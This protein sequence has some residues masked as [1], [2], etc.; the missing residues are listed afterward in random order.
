M[1]I[2]RDPKFG[3][4]LVFWIED[5]NTLHCMSKSNLIKSIFT[6]ET[7][8]ISTTKK[9]IICSFK[10]RSPDT[11]EGKREIDLTLNR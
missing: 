5:D 10:I 3:V 2:L 6:S 1:Q 8:P 4:D 9:S 11:N 7:G